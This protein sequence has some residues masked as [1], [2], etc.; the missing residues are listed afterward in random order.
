MAFGEVLRFAHVFQKE[1]DTLNERRPK[2]HQIEYS[3]A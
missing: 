3:N 2:N 1:I